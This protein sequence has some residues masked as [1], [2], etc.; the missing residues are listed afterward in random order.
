MGGYL[1]F[2]DIRCSLEVNSKGSLLLSKEKKILRIYLTHRLFIVS[3][4]KNGF[5]KRR[6]HFFFLE[7][8]IYTS[9]QQRRILIDTFRIL[10][11]CS[12][13]K[14]FKAE[15]CISLKDEKLIVLLHEYMK[16]QATNEVNVFLNGY[17]SLSRM[18]YIPKKHQFNI[19]RACYLLS[20]AARYCFDVFYIY[21]GVETNPIVFKY[22]MISVDMMNR[23]FKE[24]KKGMF[25]GTGLKHAGYIDF[26]ELF[27][28]FPEAH[29]LHHPNGSDSEYRRNNDIARNKY[30]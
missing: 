6:F 28:I 8:L 26:K 29:A 3:C 19:I 27:V 18:N 22:A 11:Y 7:S 2:A 5:L 17:K 9:D 24:L 13:L 20:L 30:Y 14:F 25:L 10:K 21:T 15:L 4:F 16:N 23:K 12:N 1:Q